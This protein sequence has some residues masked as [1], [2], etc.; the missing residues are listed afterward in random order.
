LPAANTSSVA[1]V[2]VVG[3]SLWKDAFKR[4]R[5]NRLAVVGFIVSTTVAAR[6]R[7]TEFAL[8]R[9]LGLSGGQLRAWLSLE[10]AVLA[11]ISLVAGTALGLAMAWVALPFVT[12][13]QRAAT[14]FPPVLVRV[15]W[16]AVAALEVIG[17]VALGASVIIVARLMRGSGITSLLRAGED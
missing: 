3:T 9:A 6:E 15:P 4:L 5:R 10:S 16:D 8:L 17:V 1:D 7:L 12:V 13:T 2:P 11:V 14:P